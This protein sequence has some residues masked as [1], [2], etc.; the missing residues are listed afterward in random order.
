MIHE[1]TPGMDNPRV[2]AEHVAAQIDPES[3]QQSISALNQE[4][5]LIEYQGKPVVTLKMIDELH[6]RPAGTAGRNFRQHRQR[7]REGGDYFEADPNALGDEF[8]RPIKGG[9]HDTLLLLTESGYLMIVKSFTDDLAWEVQRALVANY[10][11]AKRESGSATEILNDPDAIIAIAT[12]MKKEREARLLAEA[13]REEQFQK[14]AEA[15]NRAH[16]SAVEAEAMRP[17]AEWGEGYRK[18]ADSS[19]T[20]GSF[21]EGLRGG[22]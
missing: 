12:N 9:S 10:F 19:R 1:S 4:V 13:D 2:Q 17:D 3:S 8:R 16:A 11:R 6:Q 22:E 21:A 20:V 18:N 5:R 7:L 15:E 14:R